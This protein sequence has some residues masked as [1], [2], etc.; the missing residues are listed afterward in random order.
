LISFIFHASGY[1][2]YT[3]VIVD[4]DTSLVYFLFIYY[5][6]SV[7]IL[8]TKNSTLVL[9]LQQL[10]SPAGRQKVCDADLGHLSGNCTS[11]HYIT[12]H[13]IRVI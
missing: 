7:F 10:Q 11:V 4:V 9:K 8:I 5:D 3:Y 13:Y 1:K 2:F 6:I 12:L